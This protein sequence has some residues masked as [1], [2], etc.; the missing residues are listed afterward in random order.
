[1]VLTNFVLAAGGSFNV[2]CVTGLYV[3][4]GFNPPIYS[5]YAVITLQVYVY[6]QHSVF[7]CV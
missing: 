6:L 3:Y 4:I 2:H 1:M 7:T 5:N